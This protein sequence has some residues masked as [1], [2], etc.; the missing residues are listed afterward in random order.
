MCGSLTGSA[1]YSS[2][3]TLVNS[4]LDLM[5]EIS[6]SSAEKIEN[7]IESKF[8]GLNILASNPRIKDPN[9]SWKDKKEVLASSLEVEGYTMIG[10][11]DLAG[12]VTYTDGTVLDIKDREYFKEA[13]KGDNCVS[14]TFKSKMDGKTI[15]AYSAPIKNNNSIIGALIA[16]RDSD[17]LSEMTNKI[18]FLSTGECFILDKEGKVIAAKDQAIV[19]RMDNYIVENNPELQD[20]IEIEKEMIQGKT[21]VGEYFYD[22]VTKYVSYYPMKSTGWSLAIAV[23]KDDLLSRLNGLKST[24]ISIGLIELLIIGILVVIIIKKMTDG[25]LAVKGHMDKI[26]EGDFT[27]DINEK[28]INTSDEIGAI[29]KVLN[30][31]QSS[32]GNMVGTVKNSAGEIDSSAINLAAISE[33]LSAL[34]HNISASILEVTKGTTKQATDLTTIVSKLNEFSEQL[35]EVAININEIDDMTMSVSESSEKSKNDMEDVMISITSFDN[36]FKNFMKSIE[37]MDVDIKTVNEITDLI[38]SI[39]EQTNLLALNAA[40]EAARAGESGKG[41][42]VVADEIRKLAERSKESSEN[43]YK[44]I[45]KLLNNTKIIVSETDTMNNDLINQK[46]SIENSMKSFNEISIAFG[47]IAPRINKINV[48]FEDI[49]KNKDNIINTIEELSSISEEISASSEEIS[50][51][52]EELNNSSS[53]VAT[54][55]QNLTEKVTDMMG[56]INKFKVRQ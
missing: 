56:E 14:S 8:I 41:F 43:I 31:T 24:S 26:A 17:I 47:D 16:I 48:T 38:N 27:E 52:S 46:E 15:I 42:A 2:K 35:N 54:S 20:L 10:I 53:E 22:G 6:R 45:N 51:S 23:H 13:I 28:Y 39:A 55:A 36:K 49:N 12:K 44:I 50:A 5:S 1:Y 30:I 3:K 37:D 32:I 34:T 18:N 19:D 11:A 7:E 9:I 21:G 33:E 25:L 40:I 29:C 4:S